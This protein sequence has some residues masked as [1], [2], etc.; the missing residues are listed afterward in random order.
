MTLLQFDPLRFHSS[1]AILASYFHG[2]EPPTIELR[3]SN[4]DV[5]SLCFIK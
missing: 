3:D 1:I 5:F 4:S 2:M